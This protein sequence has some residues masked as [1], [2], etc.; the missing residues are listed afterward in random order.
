M[1]LANQFNMSIPYMSRFFLEH[2]GVNFVDYLS[3]KRMQRACELLRTTDDPV[4]EIVEK[5]GYCNVS[6]FTRKFS[7]LYDVTPGR[8]R[9]KR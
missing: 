2:S 7:E 4:R 9:S 8:F 1:L 5:V 3:Q 6:S